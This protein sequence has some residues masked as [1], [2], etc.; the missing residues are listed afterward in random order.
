LAYKPPNLYILCFVLAINTVLFLYNT[1]K[2]EDEKGEKCTKCTY[3][4]CAN[5]KKIKKLCI[6]SKYYKDNSKIC[7]EIR[8][9]VVIR[10]IYNKRL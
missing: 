2:S 9:G 1:S 6:F 3:I 5:A 8:G 7:E 4:I 10:L